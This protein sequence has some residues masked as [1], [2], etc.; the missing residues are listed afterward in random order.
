MT[1]SDFLHEVEHVRQFDW[2]DFYL[3]SAAQAARGFTY[4][5]RGYSSLIPVSEYLV[6]AVDDTYVYVFTIRPD[7]AKLTNSGIPWDSVDAEDLHGF[8]Y[9]D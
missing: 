1:V 3:L 9:P 6:R 2:G 8:V 4:I 7:A 5:K